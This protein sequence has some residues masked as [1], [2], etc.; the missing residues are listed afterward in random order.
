LTKIL[1]P[2]VMGA[3]WEIAVKSGNFAFVISPVIVSVLFA[4][5]VPWLGENSIVVFLGVTV[6]LSFSCRFVFTR[7]L[8]SEIRSAFVPET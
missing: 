3:Q 7:K 8:I 4:V 2:V 1:G 5:S 6:A